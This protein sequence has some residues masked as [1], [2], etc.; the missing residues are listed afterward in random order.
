MGAMPD[1]HHLPRR[2]PDR[3][4]VVQILWC[5]QVHPIGW[6]AAVPR[7]DLQ[8]VLQGQRHP[9]QNKLPVQSRVQ[10]SGGGSSQKC[11]EAPGEMHQ[12]RN[13]LPNRIGRVPQL[14]QSRQ[15]LPRPHHDLP[16]GQRPAPITIRGQEPPCRG[17]RHNGGEET[18]GIICR[19]CRWK[20][21]SRHPPPWS[22]RLAA[23]SNL[24]KVEQEGSSYTISFAG[25]RLVRVVVP[26]KIHPFSRWR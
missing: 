24:G 25:D 17:C 23:R 16:L 21:N 4:E 9:P 1:H 19:S 10:R 5:P 15:L 13:R 11:H 3:Q 14:P 22:S 6:G 20:R 26:L 18:G 12:G 2:H 8:D 7:R